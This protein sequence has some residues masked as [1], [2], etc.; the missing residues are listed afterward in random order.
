LTP[1][2]NLDP[3]EDDGTN[4][5]FLTNK[6]RLVSQIEPRVKA[7]LELLVKGEANWPLTLWG[8]PGTGKTSAALCLLDRV[9]NDQRKMWGKRAIFGRG[10][11]TLSDFCKRAN[12]AKYNPTKET[13]AGFVEKIECATLIV[14]DEIDRMESVSDTRHENLT[15]LL[16]RREGMPL[17]LLSNSSPD[18]LGQ[19]YGER[20]PSR[21]AKGTIW[22]MEGPDRRINKG[23]NNGR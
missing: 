17:V 7:I 14:I 21:M 12:D 2:V 16:D 13:Y 6:I 22:K 18:Q 4:A 9:A 5:P 23:A 20:V 11:F 19:M 1:K 8:P 15:D 3:N 10:Y